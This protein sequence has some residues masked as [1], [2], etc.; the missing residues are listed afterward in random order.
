MGGGSSQQ[1]GD[2]SSA[3]IIADAT[4]SVVQDIS[5][6]VNAEEVISVRCDPAACETCIS[7]VKNRFPTSSA[8]DVQSCCSPI[9]KCSVDGINMSEQISVN[10]KA[11][12]SDSSKANFAAQIQN[13]VTLKAKQQGGDIFS[14]ADREKALRTSSENIHQYI[15]DHMEQTIVQSLTDTQVLSLTGAGSI[16]NASLANAAKVIQTAVES[17]ANLQSSITDLTENIIELTTEV[18]SAGL[19]ELIKWIVR[20][21]LII[22]LIIGLGVG[23]SLVS[24]FYS[25]EAR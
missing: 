8:S 23:G 21:V 5:Q 15:S 7:S 10:F 14:S 1:V 3:S 17:E 2:Y 11:F 18:E 24:Q 12:Q 16:T 20:I 4:L 9:C 22:L 13:S 25:L 19:E 6:G